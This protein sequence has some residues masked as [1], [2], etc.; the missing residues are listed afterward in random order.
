MVQRTDY[1][2]FLPKI[3]L[4]DKARVI[5]N[6]TIGEVLQIPTSGKVKPDD[7]GALASHFAQFVSKQP[8]AEMHTVDA[9]DPNI[10]KI[11]DGNGVASYILR[12]RNIRGREEESV[13]IAVIQKVQ[14]CTHK[15]V[16]PAYLSELKPK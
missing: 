14:E 13:Q 11:Q 12:I 8:D 6:E 2:S 1:V 5:G 7:I 10:Y 16:I 9:F 3:F 15:G 4:V